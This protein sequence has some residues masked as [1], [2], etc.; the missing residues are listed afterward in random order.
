[1]NSIF[2]TRF[3]ELGEELCKIATIDMEE[4]KNTLYA[5]KEMQD[6]LLRFIYPFDSMAKLSVEQE[7]KLRSIIKQSGEIVLSN[8]LSNLLDA[9]S[10][11]LSFIDF[12]N[13]EF[14]NPMDAIT[15]TILQVNKSLLYGLKNLPEIESLN[16]PEYFEIEGNNNDTVNNKRTIFVFNA[17]F[18]KSCGKFFSAVAVLATLIQFIGWLMPDKDAERMKS[19]SYEIIR[20]EKRQT[21]ILKSMPNYQDIKEF[22][23]TLEMAIEKFENLE[24]LLS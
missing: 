7:A 19:I 10:A 2:A 9:N 18:R 13:N 8:A 11:T 1:M 12:C 15:E 20:E 3:Q 6:V 24:E 21:E 16:Y 22:Q 17:Q 23:A 4:Q 5:I 14:F